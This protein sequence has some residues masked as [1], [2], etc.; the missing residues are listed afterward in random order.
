LTES[1]KDPRYKNG[2]IHFFTVFVDEAGSI[3]GVPSSD[4]KKEGAMAEA[5]SKATVI[6]PGTRNG[7]PVPTA[8]IVAIPESEGTSHVFSHSLKIED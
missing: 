6:K 5:L 7:I 2:A 3:L 1:L 8:V 4:T